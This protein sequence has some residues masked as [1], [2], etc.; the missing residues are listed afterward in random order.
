MPWMGEIR[1][2]QGEWSVEA[3][4][5]CS[6]SNKIWKLDVK[7]VDIKLGANK[8]EWFCSKDVCEILRLKDPK[9]ALLTK[10]KQ[11]YKADLNSM[12]VAEKVPANLV[13]YHAGKVVC[14][15]GAGLY[16]LIFF[17]N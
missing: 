13:S 7:Q 9:D 15:L 17:V 6:N 4:D 2:F 14:I 5:E 16:Q 12:V 10:V 3:R 8:R 11:A 1:V